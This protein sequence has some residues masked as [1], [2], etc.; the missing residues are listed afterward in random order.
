MTRGE[1]R[2]AL[3]FGDEWMMLTCFFSV[4]LSQPAPPPITCRKTG[5]R[6]A[7]AVLPVS[8]LR[9]NRIRWDAR[10]EPKGPGPSP[11]ST[12][13]SLR[14]PPRPRHPGGRPGQSPHQPGCAAP[15]HQLPPIAASLV[16]LFAHLRCQSFPI[17]TNS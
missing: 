13:G 16:S 9:E 12:P 2:R 17:Q 14:A 3:M 1:S 11:G 10:E 5:S 4:S 8:Q 7:G 6:G 15:S